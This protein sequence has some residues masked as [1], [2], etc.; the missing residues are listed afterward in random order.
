M[1]KNLVTTQQQPL[2]SLELKDYQKAAVRKRFAARLCYV[3]ILGKPSISRIFPHKQHSLVESVST[4]AKLCV[5]LNM[6]GGS[7]T[8]PQQSSISYFW[9][10]SVLISCF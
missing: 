6:I 9:W 2:I 8:H 1:L 5:P 3:S 10:K 4:N 7:H